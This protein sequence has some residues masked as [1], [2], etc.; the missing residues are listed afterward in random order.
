M[1]EQTPASLGKSVMYRFVRS[2]GSISAVLKAE[3]HTATLESD[4]SD[5]VPPQRREVADEGTP[6][7]VDKDQ[8]SFPG[9]V[10]KFKN[11]SFGMGAST[12]DQL[13]SKADPSA[14]ANT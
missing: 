7:T 6:P 12:L 11:L 8:F 2:L 5:V 9:V 10:D 3:E 13:L 4:N 1:A 14:E